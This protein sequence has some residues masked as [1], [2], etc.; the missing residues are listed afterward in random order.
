MNTR[1]DGNDDDGDDDD[2]RRAERAAAAALANLKEKKRVKAGR[3][4]SVMKLMP[5]FLM[6]LPIF[7]VVKYFV[8]DLRAVYTI[9][10]DFKLTWVEFFYITGIFTTAIELLKTA[11]PGESKTKEVGKMGFTAGI[12]AILFALG[13]VTGR[14]I[15]GGLLEKLFSNTEFMVLTAC[16][17]VQ[18]LMAMTLNGRL[19]GRNITTAGDHHNI[20]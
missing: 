13:I 11:H 18:A 16:S 9:A 12:Y 5:I 1:N 14:M 3:F 19:A 8:G 10:G 4:F 2:L 17:I 6:V 20:N 15:E 7:M